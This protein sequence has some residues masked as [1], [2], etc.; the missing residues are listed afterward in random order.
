[1]LLSYRAG[2]VGHPNFPG[3]AEWTESLGRYWSHGGAERIVEASLG[4]DSEVWLLTAEGDFLNFRNTTTS[5][6]PDPYEVVDPADEYRTLYLTAA[7]WE[8]H[9]LDGTVQYFQGDGKWDETV[10]RSGNTEDA[11]YNGTTG[12]LETI[13]FPDGREEQF[14]YHD[15][16]TG[17]LE[18]ITEVGVDGTS[19]L[20]W[21]YSWSGDDL[22]QIDRPDGTALVFEY[23]DPSN[24]SHPPGYMTRMRLEG[25]SSGSRLLRAWEY[26]AAGNVVAT[27]R[28]TED[29]NDPDVL[30]KSTFVYDD[31]LAPTMTT[32]TDPLGEETVYEY[33]YVDRKFRINDVSGPCPSCGFGPEV[34]FEYDDVAN[35]LLPTATI[36]AR[37]TRTELDYDANG[38]LVCRREDVT[39][40][41]GPFERAT[42]WTYD[43]TFPAFP[44][45]IRRPSVTAAA[46]LDVCNPAVTSDVHET[47]MVY[48]PSNGD[49]E[50]RAVT[51]HEAT[52]DMGSECAGASAGELSCT[53]SFTYDA[54]S[55]R[56]DS[57]DPPGFGTAD[58]TT[59]SYDPDTGDPERGRQFPFSRTDPIVGATRFEYDA[60]NRRSAVV[61]PN[62]TR[63]ET[64]YDELDR[65]LTTRVCEVAAAEDPCGGSGLLTQNI[66]DELR[67][68]DTTTLPRGNKI[69]YTYDAA[70]RLESIE[71]NPAAAKGERT[72]YELDAAGNRT[73]E[74]LEVWDSGLG[75][76]SAVPRAVTTF[77]YENRCF[78][79][80]T[81]QGSG[82]EQSVTEFAYDC[83]GNLEKVWDPNHPSATSGPTQ[84]NLYDALDRLSEVRQP[85]TPSMATCSESDATGCA[86]TSYDY[87]VQD[88]LVS[89]EDAEG[90]VTTYEYS[91]RD[92]LTQ[93]VSPVSGTT[94]HHYNDHGQLV[95]TTDARSVTVTRI[96]DALD[97]V[98]SI[99]YPD[100]S[101]DTTFGYDTGSNAL[102]RLTSITRGTSTVAYAYDGLGR[103]TADGDLGIV[104]DA[105]GN[106]EDIVYPGGVTAT[107]TYDFADRPATLTVDDGTS[108]QS[109]VTAAT[110]EPSGP[111]A[112]LALG[113]GVVETRAFDQR[114]FPDSIEAEGISSVLW[115]YAIDDVGNVTQIARTI[116]CVDVVSLTNQAISGTESFVACNQLSAG[117]AVTVESGA[118]VSFQ[119]G[120]SVS[121]NNDFS[122]EQGATFSI[123]VGAFTPQMLTLDY[124]YQPVQ[125]FL[126]SATGGPW[127]SL[128]WTYDKIGNRLTEDRDGVASHE[129][130]YVSNGSG[131]TPIL[132]EILQGAPIRTFLYDAAGNLE[133][134]DTGSFQVDFTIDDDSRIGQMTRDLASPP[135]PQ[136]TLTYDGRSFLTRS[137][138]LLSGGPD[139]RFTEPTY[140]S[141]GRVMSLLRKASPTSPDEW[142]SFFYFGGRP[143][144][145][146]TQ[147]SGGSDWAFLTT[148][149]LGTPGLATDLAGD[150]V[151]QGPFEPFGRDPFRGSASGALDNGVFLR[152]PGQWEDDSWLDAA[153]GADLFYNVHRWYM[154]GTGSYATPDPWGIDRPEGIAHLYRY[155]DNN[156]LVLADPEGLSTMSPFRLL[157]NPGGLVKCFY[158]LFERNNR[159]TSCT[160]E[161][162]WITLSAGPGGGLSFGCDIWPPTG[163]QEKISF[164]GV[165]PSN[166]VGQAHT[167]PTRCPTAR[168]RGPRPSLPD[169][170]VANT[171]QIPVCTI[172]AQGVWCY[173][174]HAKRAERVLPQN[175]WREPRESCEPCTG[176]PEP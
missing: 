82:A 173:Q 170:E 135:D 112:M 161:A 43:S 130:Q 28:G 169:R 164:R 51:G 143:V 158:C 139:V 127:T 119:A 33:D 12:K 35:P 122:V 108:V 137:E 19:M 144:A 84:I 166:L 32:M 145:Q 160:E 67:D 59:W 30:D 37:G 159:G 114:Y 132:D 117:P 171:K 115:D 18:S 65:V 174:P 2:G 165:P 148:D 80:K 103:M 81:I 136:T 125:Y 58:V 142:V 104:P 105:N 4:D 77:E 111:L 8:L 85:W 1:V 10:D 92:L 141:D 172:S 15:S 73:L 62:L 167:H 57:Q 129:Y 149:H 31:P 126:T 50:S 14:T 54:T 47:M 86:V 44:E 131:N 41:S 40:P 5:S 89:V 157:P 71:R 23:D 87:D 42:S 123:S 69:V 22:M 150:E 79:K 133:T 175:W 20:T 26:D 52:I 83:N 64:T 36:D 152:F 95:S 154:T 118:D 162:A 110:Y 63:T 98:T 147:V 56:I 91:D 76:W 21:L 106:I 120:Q 49:L 48:D 25:T 96:V 163:Q 121:L 101:L 55:G 61:D 17:K 46:G 39:S 34:S 90:N 102:G 7:G 74:R 72:F 66:Y 6:F 16:G 94:T 45:L 138:E 124:Q 155:A 13:T 60:F 53:T 140:G 78:V 146:L 11:T 107:Y 168:G 88:H 93:E 24:P 153:S 116:D 97:R 176:I 29:K 99:D 151:W 9:G 68:L 109:V 156:P 128:A 3:S 75:D 113:N 134:V 100:S 27:W 38:R 70:G